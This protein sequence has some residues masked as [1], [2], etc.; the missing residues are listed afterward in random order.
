[1]VAAWGRDNPW[2]VLTINSS[3][4]IYQCFPGEFWTPQ[5]RVPF[6][7]PGPGLLGTKHME[8]CQG[9]MIEA[10]VKLVPADVWGLGVGP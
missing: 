3:F 7:S 10:G 4:N 6:Y 5:G 1:M 8:G 2:L 9:L